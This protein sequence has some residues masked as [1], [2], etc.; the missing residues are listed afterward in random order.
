MRKV[1]F[2]IILAILFVI[3]P[4]LY[5]YDRLVGIEI[6]W[7]SQMIW[8]ALLAIGWIVVSLGYFRQ[9]WLVHHSG[10]AREVSVLLPMAAFSVQC[11]LFVKGIYYHDW[12]LIAGAIMVNSGVVFCLYN[13]FKAKMK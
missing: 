8:S 12:S 6:F 13:I 5:I 4:T 1:H 11:V 9:G 7:S 3:L 10:D 2:E